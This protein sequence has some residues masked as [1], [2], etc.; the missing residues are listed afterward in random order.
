K[1]AATEGNQGFCS[2]FLSV[3]SASPRCAE[4][5]VHKLATKFW[6]EPLP[7]NSRGHQLIAHRKSLLLHRAESSLSISL[8]MCRLAHLYIATAIFKHR[9]IDHCELAGRRY[10]C[11]RRTRPRLDASVKGS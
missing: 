3:A 6:G 8:F 1:V 2:S 5:S 10:D 11:F 4:N 9:V 7:R